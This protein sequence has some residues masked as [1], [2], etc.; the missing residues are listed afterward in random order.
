[1][2]DLD[3]PRRF[4]DLA[5]HARAP[6]ALSEE[7]LRERFGEPTEVELET[8]QVWRARW[9]EVSVLVLLVGFAGRDVLVAPVTID[10][11]AED[12]NAAVLE[13]SNTVFGVECTVWAGMTTTLPVRVLDRVID[14]WPAEI[15][16]WT[17]NAAQG[18]PGP[19]PA[20]ARPGRPIYS[21]LDPAAELR[22]ELADELETLCQAPGLPVETAGATTQGLAALLGPTL[23]LA[24]LCSALGLQQPEVMKLLRGKVPFAPEQV[25]AVARATGLPAE[26]IA[27]TVRPLPLGLAQKLEHP[28]WRP[29]WTRRAERLQ[30][31]EAQAR[32]TGGYGTF[33]LAARET[34]G[35]EPDWDARIRQFLREQDDPEGGG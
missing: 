20:G 8:G 5:E 14:A 7:G 18:H 30:V 13:G 17:A 19:V 1:M 12:E 35:G 11:P 27:S 21:E 33:A 9:D 10:P 24:A 31:T 26:K 6:Q 4:L 34:G 32:L 3:V 15:V 23:D 16:R 2:G 25:E 28:R 29:A 22:A